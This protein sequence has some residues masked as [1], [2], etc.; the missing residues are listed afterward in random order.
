[1]DT[2]RDP[3]GSL[4]M[5]GFPNPFSVNLLETYLSHLETLK[6]FGNNSP[7]FVRFHGPIDEALLPTPEESTDSQSPILL[8]DIDPSSPYRGELFPVQ[9]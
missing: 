2:R 3:N 4:D 7:I 1:M 8:M 6:G 9:T 5:T